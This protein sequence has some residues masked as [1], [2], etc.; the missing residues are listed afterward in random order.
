MSSETRTFSPSDRF[1]EAQ[2][3]IH[4]ACSWPGV[5]LEFRLRHKCRI[6]RHNSQNLPYRD[7]HRRKAYLFYTVMLVVHRGKVLKFRAL[8]EL[9]FH[10]VAFLHDLF[11][12]GSI[13]SEI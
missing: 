13:D 10:K 7:Q 4:Q 6:S 12:I 2:E 5:F 9:H 8:A 3:T 1:L 11:L